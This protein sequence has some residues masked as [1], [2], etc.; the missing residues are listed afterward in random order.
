MAEIVIFSGT[1]EGRNISKWLSTKKVSHFVCVASEYG[2]QVM[3]HDPYAIVKMGR[4]DEEQIEQLFINEKIKLVVDATHPYANIVTENIKNAA[5]NTNVVY[6]R[7]ERESD[8]NINRE[9]MKI[10]YF[11][12][13]VSCALALKN[14]NGNIML[15]TGSKELSV[16]CAEPSVKERLIVRV[17]PGKES[18]ALC[19]EQE[20]PGKRIIAM[21]GPFSTEMNLALINQYDAKILVTKE[22]GV[23]GGYAEKLEAAKLADIEVYVIGRPTSVKGQSFDEVCNELKDYIKSE[24]NENIN[25]SL[26]GCGMGHRSSLTMQAIDAL[27][28]SDVVFGAERL[29]KDMDIKIENYPYYLAKDILPYTDGRYKN[30]AVLFSGDTGFYSGA[31]KMVEG[32]KKVENAQIQIYPGIS[33]VSNL[34]AITGISYDDAKIISVHGKGEITKW[35]GY[36]IKE[37]KEH[38]KIFSLLSG[39]QDLISIGKLLIENKLAHVKIYAGYQMSYDNQEVLQLSPEECVSFDNTKQGLYSIF[40]LNEKAENKLNVPGLSD[41]SF[42]RGKVPMTKEE[43]RTVSISKLGLCDN[44]VVYD[45]GSGTGSIAVEIARL[46]GNI[47]VYAIEINDEALELIKQN[48]EKYKLDNIHIIKAMA[49]E[50]LEEL[51]VPTHA[52]IGGSKGNMQEIV[53]CLLKKNP[54]IK[55][56]SNAVSLETINEFANIEKNFEIEDFQMVTLAVTRSKSVGSYHMMQSENPVYICSFKGKG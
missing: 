51:P 14:T 48:K 19:D 8:I 6:K 22:S 30:I 26:I 37:V 15:T 31:K 52:F 21:Q 10:K 17:L 4:L 1:T 36:F 27:D 2:E 11:E 53:G 34:A 54:N 16:Y 55:I 49:P 24:D 46:S 20:I 9:N 28:K 18:I 44:A 23:N 5:D 7:L 56:V 41:E 13:A 35:A 40:I 12:D 25:I 29:L 3:D 38:K 47:Q 32:L 50:G 42:I 39:V 45:V 43:V 33:S